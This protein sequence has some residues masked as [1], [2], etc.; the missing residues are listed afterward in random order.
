MELGELDEADEDFDTE[1]E[2]DYEDELDLN[3][4]SIVSKEHI[5]SIINQVAIGSLEKASNFNQKYNFTQA[6]IILEI[7]NPQSHQSTAINYLASKEPSVQWAI[8]PSSEKTFS[9]SDRVETDFKH[10]RR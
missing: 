2:S 6:V 4:S 7:E 3:N 8:M 10:R 1:E 5:L 9:K